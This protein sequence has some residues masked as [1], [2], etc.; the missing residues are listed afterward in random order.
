[1]PTIHLELFIKADIQ[2]VFDLSRS[3]D[4]HQLSTENSNEKA[5]AGVTKGLINL[6]ESV[7]WRAKHF[8]IYQRLTSEITAMDSPNYFVDEM[9]RGA[10]KR[11]KHEHIFEATQKG[12]WMKDIFDYTSPLGPLGSLADRLFLK[13]YMRDFLRQRN[14]FI[15]EVAESERWRAIL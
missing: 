8:G 9:V 12:T 10:F 15:K 14:E 13:K 7:T 3:I 1:M 4:L 11:F 2:L 6:G 5:I